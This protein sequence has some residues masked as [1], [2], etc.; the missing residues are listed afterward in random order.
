M[1]FHCL[2][3]PSSRMSRFFANPVFRNP[4]VRQNGTNNFTYLAFTSH[5][6]SKQSSRLNPIQINLFIASCNWPWGGGFRG[7][8]SITS[9]SLMIRPPKLHRIIIYAKKLLNSD[10]LRKECSSSVTRVQTC[11]HECKTCNT[12]ANYKW[13]LIVWKHNRN[14]QEPIRLELF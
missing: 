14:H 2:K 12:S 13:F 11:K 8:P 4:G 9:K 6:V 7:P 3:L 1:I 5:V 10:W